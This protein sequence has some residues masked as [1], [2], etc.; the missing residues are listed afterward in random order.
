MAEEY[1]RSLCC[2]RKLVLVSIRFVEADLNVSLSSGADGAELQH[3]SRSACSSATNVCAWDK[4]RSADVLRPFI[5]VTF[6]L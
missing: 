4:I 5:E 3:T 6:A 1:D 2:V